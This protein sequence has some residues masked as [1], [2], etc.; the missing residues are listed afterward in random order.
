[1]TEITQ[2]TRS[3][4]SAQRPTVSMIV[5]TLGR[6]APITLLL[7]TLA[8][9]THLPLEVIFVDQNETAA[10]VGDAI[11]GEWPFDLRHIHAPGVRGASRGRNHGLPAVRGDILI[12][13]DDDCWYP[14]DFVAKSVAILEGGYDFA[15]GRAADENGRSINGRFEAEAMEVTHGVVWTTSIE[16][17][18]VVRTSAFRALGG[19][20][21]D[22]GIGAH[23]P[24]R[25][26]EAQELVFRLIQNGYRGFYSP[27]LIGHH[28]ELD[29]EEPD[30]PMRRKMRS[31]GRGMGF[32]LG[33][34]DRHPATAAF[35][36]AR[37]T[38]GAC[39]AFAKLR[40]ARA[41]MLFHVTLGRIEGRIG[42]S[43]T[44]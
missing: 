28:E 4:A 9:Q 18:Q 19:F 25:A 43:F 11:A 17:M 29:T 14:A 10:M 42:K 24:W 31:Y 20:D 21:E 15:C 26:C 3:T 39:L 12:F 7:R 44:P 35:W 40:F 2:S 16:W 38:A 5:T 23:T 1:M 27:D 33:M 8:V 34:H 32:V 36:I 30:L 22:I 13:P 37:S 6:G 41:L